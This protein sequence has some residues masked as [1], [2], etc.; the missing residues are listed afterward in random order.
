MKTSTF[1]QHLTSGCLSLTNRF[2]P[3]LAFWAKLISQFRKDFKYPIKSLDSYL[4]QIFTKDGEGGVE[5]ISFFLSL[6]N[7]S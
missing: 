7:S 4:K 6:R 2:F 3:S 1:E 5:Q